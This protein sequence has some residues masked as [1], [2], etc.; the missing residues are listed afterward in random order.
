MTCKFITVAV[1]TA[2]ASGIGYLVG[3]WVIIYGL[4]PEHPEIAPAR[5]FHEAW[6]HI[7]VLMLSLTVFEVS[8]FGCA[9]TRFARLSLGY[10]ATI[11]AE[12]SGLVAMVHGLLSDFSAFDSLWWRLILGSAPIIIVS[13]LMLI[14]FRTR[15]V[16][17][18]AA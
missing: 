14:Y 8:A 4:R 11:A 18:I 12:V 1:V 16:D 6:S 9:V 13:T 10:A 17:A 15:D 2:L 3:A 7:P 5:L